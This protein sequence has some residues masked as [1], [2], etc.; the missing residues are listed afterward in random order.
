MPL[1]LK[2]AHCLPFIYVLHGVC[3]RVASL[4]H[5]V[6][7]L[8]RRYKLNICTYSGSNA[9]YR[10]DVSVIHV[11]V[12]QH[13]LAPQTIMLSCKQYYTY[14]VPR[15]IIYNIS[16]FHHRIKLLA[17]VDTLPFTAVARKN[18]MTTPTKRTTNHSEKTF[19]VAV[20]GLSPTSLMTL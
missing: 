2:K 17:A 10:F 20:F 4:R 7:D 11:P 9:T 1:R 14:F 3:R 16:T 13:G 15:C 8:T 6:K 12:L 19:L 5:F 18:P